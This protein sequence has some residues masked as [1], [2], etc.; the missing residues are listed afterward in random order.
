M[1]SP[2]AI[3]VRDMRVGY[4]DLTAVRG[5]SFS[6]PAGGRMGLVGESGSGKSMTALALMG[7]LPAGWRT[8]GEV[9]HDGV[10][11]TT[12][13]DRAFSA[14]R[15]RTISMVFQ[16]PM[17]SLNPV[18]TI[19]AQ[20]DDMIMRH[21][22]LPPKAARDRTVELLEQVGIPNARLRAND[23][24]H[25]F[26]GGMRQ[27][28]LIAIAISCDPD[29]LIADEP[30]TALDVTVQAQILRLLMRLREE[31]G[32]SLMLITHDFGVVA[33]MVERVNVMY[34]GTIVESGPVDAIFASPEHNYTRALLEAVPR[35]DLEEISR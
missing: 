34:G 32:M 21:L 16:D 1:T 24:P 25:Q 8:D 20:V 19:G 14:R 22:G 6:V 30:T 18:M 33:G 5:V 26:S 12:E 10:N 28:V 9:L 17:T 27:R 2:A 15:G 23:H 13:P 29:L 35:L 3:E 31:R 11:L 7:L 4:E